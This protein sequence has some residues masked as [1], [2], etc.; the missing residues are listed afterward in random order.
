MKAKLQILLISNHTGD[1][2]IFRNHLAD[3]G[4]PI[5]P[6]DLLIAAQ[7][8][9]LDLMVVTANVREFQRIPNLRVENWLA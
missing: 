8:L 5:G 9:A 6:N 4:T 7:A 3:Q 2:E 1:A